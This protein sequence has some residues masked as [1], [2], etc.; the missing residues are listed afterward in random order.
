MSSLNK[1]VVVSGEASETDSEEETVSSLHSSVNV[2]YRFVMLKIINVIFNFQPVKPI[3]PIQGA[4]IAGE[5][6][7]SENGKLNARILYKE[8]IHELV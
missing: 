3:T 4:V 6:S 8:V 7:E 1:S 5:D 2:L